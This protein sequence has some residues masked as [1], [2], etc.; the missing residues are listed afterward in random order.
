MIRYQ[1]ITWPQHHLITFLSWC[2]TITWEGFRI[3]MPSR[4]TSLNIRS[5]NIPVFK[6]Q[7]FSLYPYWPCMKEFKH[8]IHETAQQW[9]AV[10]LQTLT[11]YVLCSAIPPHGQGYSHR[12]TLLHIVFS[13]L[14]FLLLRRLVTV[15]KFHTLDV[16]LESQLSRK[17]RQQ[18]RLAAVKHSL[19][20]RNG[21]ALHIFRSCSLGCI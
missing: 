15:V 14:F 5:P 12:G 9:Q 10:A 13:P 17:E 8:T 20:D 16:N 4:L 2:A 11:R 7:F 6:I 18:I 1:S 21:V 3:N 19:P